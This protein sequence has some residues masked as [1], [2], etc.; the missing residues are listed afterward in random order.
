MYIYCLKQVVGHTKSDSH[1]HLLGSLFFFTF[2]LMTNYSKYK[3]GYL[4]AGRSVERHV[5]GLPVFYLT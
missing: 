5:L 3:Y 4:M 1:L 2:D